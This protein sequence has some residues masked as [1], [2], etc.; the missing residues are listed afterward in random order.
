M[1]V[2]LN[3]EMTC[4]DHVNSSLSKIY[5]TLRRLWSTAALLPRATRLGLIKALVLP[6]FVYGFVIFPCL[7]SAC[8][9]KI[10][11]AFNDCVRFVYG[12]RRGDHISPFAS[13]LLGCPLRTYLNVQLLCVLH[14]IIYGNNPAYLSSFFTF[15]RSQRRSV[16]LLP[17]FETLVG[18]RSFSVQAARLWNSLP[19]HVRRLTG[20]GAFK[21]GVL[22]HFS[23]SE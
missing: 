11:V 3:S 15:L 19:F 20:L 22:E 8:A 7:D 16:I 2:L 17:K 13:N 1:G 9:S 23:V 18:E 5:G 6:F 10:N 14:K 12:L 21:K 4:C